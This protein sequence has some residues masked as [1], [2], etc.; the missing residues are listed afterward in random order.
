MIMKKT[1]ALILT[2]M[3]ILVA[4]LF[5]LS[6]CKPE[7][8]P[9]EITVTSLEVT[10]FP[11]QYYTQYEAVDLTGGKVLATFSDGSTKELAFTDEGVS[12]KDYG[13]KVLDYLYELKITYGGQTAV[14]NY[15]VSAT[16]N[17]VQL[18]L[19][20]MPTKYAVGNKIDYSD[21]LF[22]LVKATSTSTMTAKRAAAADNGLYKISGFDTSSTGERIMKIQYYAT[23]F[24][25]P[26]TVVQDEFVRSAVLNSE[27]LIVIYL[28]GESIDFNG[29]S[30]TASLSDGT[31]VQLS[32]DASMV[33]GFSTD[34]ATP[35]EGA[36]MTIAW[37]GYGGPDD[38][39]LSEEITY[40]V[41]EQTAIES[42]EVVVSPG[43]MNYNVGDE[44]YLSKT[45][46]EVTLNTGSVKGVNINNP[47]I[48]VTGFDSSRRTNPAR[49]LTV[50]YTIN[51]TTSLSTT[52]QYNVTP[53]VTSM[54]L[55]YGNTVKLAYAEGESFDFGDAQIAVIYDDGINEYYD[56]QDQFE[57][58]VDERTISIYTLV[59]TTGT[60][61]Y[62]KLTSEN[63][64]MSVGTHRILAGWSTLDVEYTVT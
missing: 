27:D 28:V 15:Y 23:V 42:I 20:T 36:K 43:E 40:Y 5:V 63:I 24:E 8:T 48:T 18:D 62:T 2:L 14:I 35:E 19:K 17:E 59:S 50:T 61:V 41:Y 32:L 57:L 1:Y 52:V 55:L 22:T 4:G 6:G 21:A 25:I 31:T 39:A 53:M 29:A 49:Y 13:T 54:Q 46:L 56:L 45:Y 11:E 3:L 34:A 47:R 58:P 9:E 10:E 30:I 37:P 16:I 7:D 60:S 33:S 12:V 26:Y 64:D 44:L 51:E 38:Y